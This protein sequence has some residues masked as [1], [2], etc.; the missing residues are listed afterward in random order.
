MARRP[1][2]PKY[3]SGTDQDRY[4]RM[5][6]YFSDVDREIVVVGNG[7]SLTRTDYHSI[8]ENPYVFR[9]NWFFLESVYYFGTRVDAVFWSVYNAGL[10]RELA[11]QVREKRYDIAHFLFP[12]HLQ[13]DLPSE[14]SINYPFTP[15]FDHWSLL[16]Q[17]ARLARTLMSRPLPTQGVQMIAT[18][19]ALG[20][21]HI[22]V[23]GIDFYADPENRYNYSIPDQIKT[24]LSPKDYIGGYEAA[25]ELAIDLQILR[26]VKEEYKDVRIF[27]HGLYSRYPDIFEEPARK[28]I[29]FNGVGSKIVDGALFYSKRISRSTGNSENVAYVTFATPTFKYGVMA[30]ANSLSKISSIPL[31]VMVTEGDADIDLAGSNCQ[32]YR[33][34]AISNPNAETISQKRFMETYT[35]L[36]V[37]GLN[38]LDKAVFLDADTVVLKNIDELF[39]SEEFS[40]APDIGLKP[41]SSEFNSGVFVCSPSKTLFNDMM[42][43]LRSTPSNDGGDQGFLNSYFPKAILLD[44]HY[45]VLKRVF[46]LYPLLIKSEDVKIIHFVGVKPWDFYNEERSEF[47]ELEARWFAFLTDDQKTR[48]FLEM[49]SKELSAT[50]VLRQRYGANIDLILEE[51]LRDIDIERRLGRRRALDVADELYVNQQYDAAIQ[52]SEYALRKTPRSS[53]HWFR[54]SRAQLAAGLKENALL[55]IQYAIGIKA[56]NRFRKLEAEILAQSDIRNVKPGDVDNAT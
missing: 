26:L 51:R 11:K 49:R 3:I 20:F 36:N 28:D 17:N 44:Q 54:L 53:E 12:F 9:C 46:N 8:P 27:S 25:H 31:I 6:E 19:A 1:I 14:S 41:N 29:Y 35:K 37:F 2:F 48:L 22:H 4:A 18:A 50:S 52:V 38:F 32:I 21:K 39:D 42:S 24:F 47:R 30:L 34:P 40:A 23:A 10:H 55:S 56:D 43:K 7:P 45:N 15:S 13:D 16:A 33:V 5:R